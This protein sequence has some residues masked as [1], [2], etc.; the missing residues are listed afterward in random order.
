VEH[1]FLFTDS[2]GAAGLGACGRGTPGHGQADIPY[3]TDVC[4][5]DH[6]VD[7]YHPGVTCE[8]VPDVDE[9]CVN[10][11]LVVGTPRGQW[12]A[13]NQCQTFVSDVLQ[14]CQPR[15]ECNASFMGAEGAPNACF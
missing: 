3:V 2:G 12:N 11:Q 6:T 5:E 7:L 13:I 4:V 9:S 1:Q 14:M 15:P 8:E 10:D